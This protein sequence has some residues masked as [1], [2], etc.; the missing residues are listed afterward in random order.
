MYL[1]CGNNPINFVDPWGLCEDKPW[2]PKWS[3]VFIPG[4]G[5]YGGPFR[6]DP[7]FQIR[8][9]DSMDRLFMQHDI[10]WSQGRGREADRALLKELYSL[11]SDLRNWSEPPQSSWIAGSYRRFIAESYFW[12][13]N[14]SLGDEN[15]K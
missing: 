2:W 11:P 15:G 4:Y 13:R 8:P 12:W 1:Y 6:T 14:L 10:G 5:N 7:T 9:E 3:E